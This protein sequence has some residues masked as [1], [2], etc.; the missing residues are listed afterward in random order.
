M[1]DQF[2]EISS[3]KQPT[4]KIAY[5]VLAGEGRGNVFWLNGFL[6]NMRSRK[7]SA[8]ARW[9]EG[10]GF[11]LTR[12]D[13]SGRGGSDGRVEDGTISRFLDEAKAV[14][15]EVTEGPQIV[16]G[17]SMGGWL[18]LL[19]MQALA[20]EAERFAGCVLIAPAWNLTQDLMWDRFSDEVRAEIMSKGVYYHPSDYGAYA[21]TREFIEDG[22]RHLIRPED[23]RLSCPVTILHGMGDPV[24]PWRHSMELV[25]KVPHDEVVLQLV[26]DGD[27]S[28]SRELDIE[29]L[30]AEVVKNYFLSKRLCNLLL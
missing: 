6:S 23:V 10:H 17:S 19:L 11:G 30:C 7:V 9:C 25:E 14:F 22:K 15:L 24:V 4:Y 5:D 1:P 20:D 28:L 29:R 27:H 21:V 2:L 13:Y 8:F 3:E 26:K 12:F 18:A 16:V